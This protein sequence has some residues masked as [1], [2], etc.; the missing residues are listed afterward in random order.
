LSSVIHLLSG[1]HAL[2][3]RS[4]TLSHV[5][6]AALDVSPALLKLLIATFEIILVLVLATLD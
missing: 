4:L 5:H 1:G 6:L 2:V 3:E